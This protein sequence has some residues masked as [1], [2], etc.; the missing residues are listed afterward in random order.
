MDK[1]QHSNQCFYKESLYA[2]PIP[3]AGNTTSQDF[4]LSNFPLLGGGRSSSLSSRVSNLAKRQS[5]VGVKRF[6]SSTNLHLNMPLKRLTNNMHHCQSTQVLA[7]ARLEEI[8]VK[9]ITDKDLETT[10]TQSSSTAGLE[11]LDTNKEEELRLLRMEKDIMHR[12]FIEKTHKLNLET[13]QR[14]ELLQ[15]IQR[16]RQGQNSNSSI[17]KGSLK[18]STN[19]DSSTSIISKPQVAQYESTNSL[20][21]RRKVEKLRKKT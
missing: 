4:L 19:Y 2:S 14:K 15:R 5:S 1:H 16:H 8:A 18:N 9:R 6:S 21:E 12:A 7:D 11:K 13:D 3:T 20:E 10:L 17:N